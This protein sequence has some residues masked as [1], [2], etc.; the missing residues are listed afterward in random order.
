MNFNSLNL[1]ELDKD[2]SDEERREWNA[3][4]A[5]YRSGSLLTGMVRGMDTI[6]VGGMQNINCLVVID[7]RVKVLIP[8][9]EIW[10][11]DNTKRP[12]HVLRSM[13]GA[14][15]DY[16][17]TAVDRNGECCVASRRKALYIRRKAFL[18]LPPREGQ[19]CECAFIAVG[20]AKI[21]CCCGGFDVT[22]PAKDISYA[23][24]PDLR[25]R[26]STGVIKSAIIKSYDSENG[27]LK[28]SVKEAAP[29][30]F[31]GADR[32]HP[33]NCRR[34]SVITGKY[35]GGVFCRLE[36]DLDCLCTYSPRQY[37]AD[38]HIG[39]QVI[40]VVTKFA[41]SKK[42]IYGKIVAKW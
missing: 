37:D 14:P 6:N 42:Q 38:F 27:E 35:G 5:S 22:L 18:K 1:G 23:M 33:L 25:E 19:K 8:E 9:N 34:A 2:L 36:D 13:A 21:L 7:Y 11:D 32:R 24:V 12:S 17:I 31:D 29:H 10:F 15:V 4:Y 16:V 30:P 20:R 39:D 28:I 26:F 41:Y 3:I 40:I